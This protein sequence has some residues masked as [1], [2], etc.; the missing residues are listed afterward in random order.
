V[1]S[2]R[3]PVNQDLKTGVA[4]KRHREHMMLNERVKYLGRWRIVENVD[5]AARVR[6]LGCRGLSLRAGS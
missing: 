3:T 2:R 4:S 5:V 1:T 6:E